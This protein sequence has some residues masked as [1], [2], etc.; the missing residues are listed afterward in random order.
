MVVQ[1]PAHA[2]GAERAAAERDRG[3][4]LRAV[5]ELERDL[6][7][8]RPELPLAALGEQLRDRAPGTT[9]DLRVG[10]ERG[11]VQRAGG[12]RLARAHETY[13]DDRTCHPMRSR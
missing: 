6:L 8:Q 12:G 4:G 13:E 5:E 2:L 1:R 9:F 3:P 7:L 11:R 10:V